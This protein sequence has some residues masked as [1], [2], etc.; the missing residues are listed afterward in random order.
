MTN[1][2]DFIILSLSFQN[3][4]SQL[5]KKVA[6]APGKTL[7]QIGT[8][9]ASTVPNPSSVQVSCDLIV[10]MCMLVIFAS[11]FII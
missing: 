8:S 7:A 3:S 6:V 4:S 2:D 11:F 1:T 10:A 9:M 5:I